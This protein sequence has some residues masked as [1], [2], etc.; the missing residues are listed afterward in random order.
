M[1]KLRD[2]KATVIPT[3]IG[4]FGAVTEELENH[5]KIIGIPV[6]I[7]CLQKTAFLGTAF[8]FRRVFG[9]TESGKLSDVK[10]FFSSR[11]GNVMQK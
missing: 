1:Q 6:V 3:A 2:V 5:L 4:A 7:S 8:I 10:E 9:I 11:S